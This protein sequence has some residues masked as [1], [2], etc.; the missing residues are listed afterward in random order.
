[1]SILYA[2]DVLTAYFTRNISDELTE[3]PMGRAPKGQ[4]VLKELYPFREQG[5]MGHSYSR[6]PHL[7]RNGAMV[8]LGRSWPVLVPATLAAANFAVIESAPREQR[9]GRYQMFSSG[10][11][12]TFGIG[13]GLNL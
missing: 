8:V 9:K 3:V 5:R 1:V 11:T 6:M 4:Y 13:S 7:T 2:M 10:L 12:G